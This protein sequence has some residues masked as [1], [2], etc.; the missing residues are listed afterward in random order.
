M[1]V[2]GGGGGSIKSMRTYFMDD[3]KAL[4]RSL[5]SGNIRLA[6]PGEL[7]ILQILDVPFVY[8]VFLMHV[9]RKK[10]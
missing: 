3:P 4:I 2:C 1:C 9:L 5:S 10:R 6:W 7:L 8:C